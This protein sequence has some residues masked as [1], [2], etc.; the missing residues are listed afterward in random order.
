M[1]ELNT[2]VTDK[3]KGDQSLFE[4]IK[5]YI[6]GYKGYKEKNLRRDADRAVRQE[7][8][9]AIHG[10]KADLAEIQKGVTNDFDMLMDVERIRTKVD[11]YDI[12]IKKAVNG[13]SA[14]HD[15]VK[16]LEADLDRVMEWDA[17]ILEDIQAMR[18]ATERL[19][20]MVDDGS[21]TKRDL[22]KYER[23][24]DDML[25]DYNQREAV[26]KGFEADD[27]GSI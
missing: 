3:M 21:I 4:K 10:T 16:I 6:P 13:Y 7:L 1:A 8:S 14:W 5:L 17:K 25:E 27:G 22:R 24:I 2:T 19:L 23:C 9:R 12:D 11:K 20:E 15:S 18:E 26:M